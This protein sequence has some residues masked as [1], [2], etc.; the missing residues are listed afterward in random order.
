MLSGP[1]IEVL[2]GRGKSKS[3]AS[4]LVWKTDAKVLLGKNDQMDRKHGF[5]KR[6]IIESLPIEQLQ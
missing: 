6:M 5:A 2:V 3:T 1:A 4:G